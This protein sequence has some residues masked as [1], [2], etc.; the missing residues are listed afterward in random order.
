MITT[1]ITQRFASMASRKK[2]TEI[3]GEEEIDMDILCRF[4]DR[5]F[6]GE[7]E[8]C[9]LVVHLLM[10]RNQSTSS[11][12]CHGNGI[13]GSESEEYHSTDHTQDRW[14]F[15]GQVGANICSLS[16]LPCRHVSASCYIAVDTSATLF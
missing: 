10:K 1:V 5:H 3:L 14:S 6:Y 2:S 13:S 15:I 16:S 11:S 9:N 7:S 8:D 12:R 4:I